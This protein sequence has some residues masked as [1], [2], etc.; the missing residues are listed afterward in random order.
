MP[1]GFGDRYQAIYAGHTYLIFGDRLKVMTGAEY[2]VMHNS[3]R[4][5]GEFDGWTYLAGGRVYF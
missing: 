3:A 4:D 2:S 1:D 5:G